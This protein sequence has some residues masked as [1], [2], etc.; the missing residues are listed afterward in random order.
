MTVP[1]RSIAQLLNRDRFD[2]ASR[3]LTVTRAR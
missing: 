2:A 1:T 3:L